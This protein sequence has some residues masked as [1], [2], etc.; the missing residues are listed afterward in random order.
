M[1]NK[2]SFQLFACCIPVK[3]YSRSI[4]YDVQYGKYK[5]IPNLL[6][7][8]LKINKGKT[9]DN[10][11]Y[12]T[13]NKYDEG[14][15]L[16]Y[17]LL[18]KEGYGFHTNEPELF[19]EID[20]TWRNPS[21][22][23]N[24]IIEVT[25]E[26]SHEDINK[27]IILTDILGCISVQI[28]CT[29]T[30][31]T[32]KWLLEILSCYSKSRIKS[33]ELVLLHKNNITTKELIEI[34]E[35]HRRITSIVVFNSNK[36]EKIDLKNEKG[37]VILF[38]NKEF[39]LGKKSFTYSQNFNININLFSE[40]QKH[41]TY[42]NRKLFINSKGEIKNAPECNEKFGNIN[43]INSKTELIKI[44]ATQKFQ[45]YWFIQKE[46]I[47]VCKDCEFRHMCVDS[48]LPEQSKNKSWYFE[49]ECPY[50]PY[51]AKWDGEEG[52]IPAE[53]CGTYSKENG[54]VI[55]KQKVNKL[56]KQ[57]CRE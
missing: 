1:T 48:R 24:A 46:F 27:K 47:D 9:I 54:F 4:I 57:I 40:S 15:D 41:N 18:I 34:S 49:R 42:F 33:I 19:P 5:F 7:D 51:I 53:K 37:I 31:I 26:N 11:K 52:Y 36:N 17:N 21:M 35:K 39:N 56:N 32:T 23:T 30:N 16:F 10:L 3:G 38:S 6:F 55:N 28:F 45:K 13:K 29:D 14:I 43:N 44:I 22:I 12:F 50:N 20:L 8:I 25:F 2:K